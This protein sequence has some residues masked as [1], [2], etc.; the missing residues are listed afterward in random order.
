MKKLY[1]MLAAMVFAVAGYLSPQVMAS[2]TV[3]FVNYFD[4][5]TVNC[6]TY[7][8]SETCGGWPGAPMDKTGGK[9]KGKDVYSKTFNDGASYVIFN[10]KTSNTDS[11]GTQTAGNNK[12]SIQDGALYYW[13]DSNNNESVSIL[14]SWSYD[15]VPAPATMYMFGNINGSGNDGW[16]NKTT[17]SATKQSGDVYK[18]NNFVVSQESWF[19]FIGD[20]KEYSTDENPVDDKTVTDGVTDYQT[21]NSGDK[22]FNIGAGKYNITLKW[23]NGS[24]LLTVQKATDPVVTVTDY[25][26][27]GN[28]SGWGTADAYKFTPDAKGEEYTLRVN[29]GKVLCDNEFKVGAA[30]DDNWESYTNR[31]KNM[32]VN[33][34]YSGLFNEQYSDNMKLKAGAVPENTPVTIIFN[35]KNKTIIFK[36]DQVVTNSWKFVYRIGGNEIELPFDDNNQITGFDKFKTKTSDSGDAYYFYVKYGNTKYG[37]SDNEWINPDVPKLSKVLVSGGNNVKYHF[38]GV[39]GK[40]KSYTIKWTPGIHKIEFVEESDYAYDTF[41]FN[42]MHNED[43]KNGVK[44]VKLMMLGGPISAFPSGSWSADIVRDLTLRT[45][46]QGAR[47]YSYKFTEAELGKY[48]NAA[49]Y[50]TDNNNQHH[51]FVCRANANQSMTDAEGAKNGWNHVDAGGNNENNWLKYVYVASGDGLAAQSYITYEEWQKRLVENKNTVYFTGDGVDGL[52]WNPENENIESEDGV[53]GVVYWTNKTSSDIYF[54]ISWLK[55]YDQWVKSGKSGG[56]IDNQRAWATFNMGI[57][58]FDKVKGKDYF[59]HESDNTNDNI[60]V[61]LNKILPYNRKSAENWKIRGD[62]GAVDGTKVLVLDSHSE[63]KTVTLLTF[64]PNPQLNV[65]AG[66]IVNT[67]LTPGDAAKLHDVQEAESHVFHG[68]KTN[69]LA[70]ITSLNTL[71]A[72]A[73]LVAKYAE[74]TTNGANMTVKYDFYAN[75]DVI[76]TTQGEDPNNELFNFANIA[77]GDGSTVGARGLYYDKDTKCQFHSKFANGTLSGD[78]KAA[79]PEVVIDK[80]GYAVLDENPETL[81]A[82][83]TAKVQMPSHTDMAVKPVIYPDFEVKVND[84]SSNNYHLSAPEKANGG[85]IVH[86]NHAV[87]KQYTWFDKVDYTPAT[88]ASGYDHD[89]HNWTA[90]LGADNAAWPFYLP[91]VL[92]LANEEN[93]AWCGESGDMKTTLDFTA[94]AVY[95]FLIDRKATVAV[96]TKSNAPRR[97]P[98]NLDFSDAHDYHIVLVRMPAS[99][100]VELDENSPLTGIDDIVAPEADAEAVYYTLD[101]RLAGSNPAAGVYI[102]R[103]GNKAEKIYIR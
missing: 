82:M 33:T 12:V 84:Y 70:H 46:A 26:L 45:D 8:N 83:F 59:E 67:A 44:E 85:E 18:W 21:K 35:K 87:A 79:S 42:M 27:R 97:A 3:Y 5:T 89:T 72:T 68:E 54:K 56:S 51:W 103:V 47:M 76:Y 24:P 19:R 77:V 11:G 43:N 90:K 23:N 16:N 93:K 88:S 9:Y 91:D 69:G 25:W 32:E 41:Y 50:I 63:C 73:T 30:G 74:L 94:Y 49:V 71:S 92:K 7:G 78:F 39:K 40:S 22:A 81:S 80:K 29:N 36:M 37:A 65:E 48:K 4:W 66:S 101:G 96:T 95:P 1:F 102:R 100:T 31:N 2:K 55:P 14:T 62:D 10:N 99:T 98:A 58:A 53:D 52:S 6:Y 61:N 60:V 86:S 57:I 38:N 13:T 20:S 34:T 15:A 28:F 64:E 17:N 75:G